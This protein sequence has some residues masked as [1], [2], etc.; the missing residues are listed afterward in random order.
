MAQWV[1]DPTVAQIAVIVTAV[2]RTVARRVGSMPGLGTSA[3]HRHD[4]IN[5]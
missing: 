1:K 3:C 2:A 4:Q 5:K